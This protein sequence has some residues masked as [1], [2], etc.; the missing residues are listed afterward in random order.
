MNKLS[1][2]EKNK[3]IPQEEVLE[4]KSSKLDLCRDEKEVQKDFHNLIKFTIVI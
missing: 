4:L 3:L 1:S 2:I